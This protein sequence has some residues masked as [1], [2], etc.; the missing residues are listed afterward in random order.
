MYDVHLI[1]FDHKPSKMEIYNLLNKWS[2]R[3]EMDNKY[4]VKNGLDNEL[5]MKY[6]GFEPNIGFELE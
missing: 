6:F 5:W 4:S 1:T 2:F 3:F